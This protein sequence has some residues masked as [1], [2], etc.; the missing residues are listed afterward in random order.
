MNP[1]LIRP[2]VLPSQ[3]IASAIKEGWIAASDGAD[4]PDEN[5]QPASLDLRLGEVAYPLRCSFLPD[6]VPVEDALQDY[7]V[8]KTDKIDL[9]KGGIL[10]R[11]S[12]YLVPL[13]ERLALPESIRAKANPKSS[14][15]RLDIFTRLIID[16]SAK[17]D[18]VPAGY[19]GSLYLEIVPRT[20]TVLARSGQTLNQL[21]L[22]VGDSSLSDAEIL[23][24]HNKEPLLF[25]NG[26]ALPEHEVSVSDGLLLGL[27]LGRPAGNEVVGYRARE[28]AVFIDLSKENYYPV[29][30]FWEEVLSERTKRGPMIVL[31]REKF[32][33]LLSEDSVKIPPEYAAEM[34][35]YDPT[36][37]ELRT[38]YAG[39]FDPGFGYIPDVPNFAGSRVALEVRAHDAPFAV[40]HGRQ[41]CRLSLERM[42]EK[43]D[44]L[45]GQKIGSNY[46]GQEIALSKHFKRRRSG[47]KLDTST[48]VPRDQDTL[49]PL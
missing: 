22:V 16:R 13:V 30:P 26:R 38:H 3:M 44:R 48:S 15:G 34:V 41:I 43:P 11:D 10:H 17:F 32:Y 33:L 31:D 49:F 28:N 8:A 21:R 18:E 29:Q 47:Q 45:Y 12:I 24:L 2:G 4:I 42:I 5:I 25:R 36:S 20:F 46:Q 37:G 19:H 27:Y 7:R 9:T 1:R 39:F 6:D 35:A 23:A 14:T 40:K